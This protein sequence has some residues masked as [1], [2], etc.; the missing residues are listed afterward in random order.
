LSEHARGH[1]ARILSFGEDSRSEVHLE[2]VA[3]KPDGSCVHAIVA[4][5]PVTYRIAAPGRHLVQNSLAVLGA[6]HALGA[7]LARVMLALADFTA[8]KG[9]GERFTLAHPGGAFIL[10]D[11]SYNANPTSMR[12][13]LGLL[14]QAEEAGADLVFLVGPLMENLWRDLPEHRRGAYSESVAALE[15]ILLSSVGPGDV[16]MVKASLGTRLGPL[17]EALKRRYAPEAG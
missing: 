8:P 17:V 15:P 5:T 7:D 9:R 6:A 3:L 11:E 12:A 10:I 4:G 13:A 1:G 16:V 2:R 14:R